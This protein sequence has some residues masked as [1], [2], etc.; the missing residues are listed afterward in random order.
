MKPT[1]HPDRGAPCLR[2]PVADAARTT[3]EGGGHAHRPAAL[4]AASYRRYPSLSDDGEPWFP[5]FARV[6]TVRAIAL[7]ALLAL[8][9][10]LAAGR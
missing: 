3:P 8:I 7:T 6:L 9:L 5:L 10:I 1:T 4:A 2:T